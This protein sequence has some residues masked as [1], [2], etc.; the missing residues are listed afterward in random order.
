MSDLNS[1]G[2]F[3]KESIERISS[4]EQID[5][6]IRIASPSALLILV[7]ILV[8]LV[9]LIIWSVFGQITVQGAAGPESIAPISLIFK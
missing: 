2:L 5:D 3:R 7:A 8:V 1:Q 6:Y 4:P 9:G